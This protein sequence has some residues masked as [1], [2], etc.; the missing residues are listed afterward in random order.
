MLHVS[1]RKGIQFT[2]LC[3][4]WIMCVLVIM[5]KSFI[6]Y[7][8]PSRKQDV[9]RVD[10][11]TINMYLLFCKKLCCCFGQD[12]GVNTLYLAYIAIFSTNYNPFHA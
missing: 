11:L 2:A 5:V 4:F 10:I 9:K 6:D 3:L 8:N 7:P 12:V 1:N